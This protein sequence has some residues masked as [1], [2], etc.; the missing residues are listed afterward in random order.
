MYDIFNDILNEPQLF[1]LKHFKNLVII[2][3]AHNFTLN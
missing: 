1:T 3:F 2:S